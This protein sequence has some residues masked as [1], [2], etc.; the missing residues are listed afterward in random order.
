MAFTLNWD[1]KLIEMLHNCEAG[2]KAIITGD[3]DFYYWDSEKD[4]YSS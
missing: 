2:E 3:T 1:K 4:Q